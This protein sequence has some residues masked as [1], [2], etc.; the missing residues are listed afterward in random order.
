MIEVSLFDK[1]FAHHKDNLNSSL[2]FKSTKIKFDR[3]NEHEIAVGTQN[4]GYCGLP[5]LYVCVIK[6]FLS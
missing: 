1:S 4:T 2:F 3:D 5:N 6:Y